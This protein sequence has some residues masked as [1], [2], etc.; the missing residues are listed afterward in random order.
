MFCAKC[1]IRWRRSYS[2]TGPHYRK[3]WDEIDRIMPQWSTAR[4]R[5]ILRQVENWDSE[6]RC[7]ND[8]CG[9]CLIKLV[10]NYLNLRLGG[11]KVFHKGQ[12][13]ILE[14]GI[15]ANGHKR[16]KHNCNT[17]RKIYR[18]ANKETMRAY[19]RLQEKRR[20]V[21]EANHKYGVWSSVWMTLNE[22]K[23]EVRNYG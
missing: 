18:D 7:M 2:L 9:V 22:L 13:S 5:C 15:C 10:K 17:C 19:Y 4:M 12:T 1:R 14:S 6:K 3:T 21:R 20:R 8:I 16:N 23:R 11:Y